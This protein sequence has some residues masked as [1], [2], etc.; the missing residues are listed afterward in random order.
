MRHRGTIITGALITLTMAGCLQEDDDDAA[1][2]VDVTAEEQ[3]VRNQ[4][5]AWLQAVTARDAAASAAMF[6]PDGA[7]FVGNQQPL[8][9]PPAIQAH[10]Q[11]Q[12][13]QYPASRLTWTTEQVHVAASG[14][15]AYEVGTY[16]WTSDPARAQMEDTGKFV[17]VWRKIDGAWKAVVDIGTST[18]PDSAAMTGPAPVDTTL[19]P[20]PATPRDTTG[21]RGTTTPRDTARQDTT[22]RQPAP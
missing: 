12:L 15:L 14:D 4:S 5:A 13:T 2:Q 1:A 20:R 16:Q 3:A 21:Q 17:T 9:G 19:S 7:Y 18:Q 22:Q 11:Q 8:V 10:M 6:A